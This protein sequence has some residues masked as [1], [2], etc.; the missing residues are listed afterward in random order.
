MCKR[1]STLFFSGFVED[2]G[3]SAFA[4]ILTIVVRGHEH[5][6]TA[7]FAAALFAETSDFSV[8]VDLVT[9][10]K[11]DGQSKRE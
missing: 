11:G 8:L 2:D 10:N 5:S 4:A 6:G 7:L 9:T 3:Q 1:K